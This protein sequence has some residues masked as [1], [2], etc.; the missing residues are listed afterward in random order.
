MTS[1][2]DSHFK[3]KR[4]KKK[5]LSH[6]SFSP[7][8]CMHTFSSRFSPF[9]SLVFFSSQFLI[10]K[11]NLL[12]LVKISYAA[13]WLFTVFI[14]YNFNKFQYHFISYCNQFCK[15]TDSMNAL[16][17]CR[18]FLSFTAFPPRFTLLSGH[19]ST[20]T[21]ISLTMFFTSLFKNIF[22]LTYPNNIF[23]FKD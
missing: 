17:V 4:K 22:S 23:W 3:K 7:S 20:N 21:E 12:I 19:K 13:I 8:F 2:S 15:S 14:W 18:C 1:Q 10:Q 16:F 11:L 5:N 9:S 6:H